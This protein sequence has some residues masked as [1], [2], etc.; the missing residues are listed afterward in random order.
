M[1]AQLLRRTPSK[2]IAATVRVR[3]RYTP[4]LIRV[5]AGEPARIAFLREEFAPCSERVVFPSLGLNVA[6]PAYEEV[7]VDLG[8]QQPGE[9]EFTCQLGVLRGRVIVEAAERSTT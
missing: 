3:G 7:V 6:L 9:Y 8:V 1:L 2:P 4:E 5:P